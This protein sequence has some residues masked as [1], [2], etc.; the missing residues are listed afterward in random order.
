MHRVRSHGS[1]VVYL[2]SPNGSVF[3]QRMTLAMGNVQ[4]YAGGPVL[5]VTGSHFEDGRREVAGLAFAGLLCADLGEEERRLWG[6]GKGVR[7]IF[8]HCQL[9]LA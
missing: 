7:C 3:K 2:R 6:L 1:T 4:T 9:W 8:G 5:S